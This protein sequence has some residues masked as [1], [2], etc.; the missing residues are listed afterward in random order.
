MPIFS[1][2]ISKEDH[3]FKNEAVSELSESRNISSILTPPQESPASAPTYTHE[4][5]MSMSM[6]DANQDPVSPQ[7]TPDEAN[8]IIHSHRKVRYGKLDLLSHHIS[9]SVFVSGTNPV[10][11]RHNIN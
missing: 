4:G 10:H 1:T 11:N 3:D 7:L 6:S 9:H 2:L 8:R 5:I